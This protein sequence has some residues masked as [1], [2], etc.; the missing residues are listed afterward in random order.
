MAEE[1]EAAEAGGSGGGSGSG[2]GIGGGIGGSALSAAGIEPRTPTRRGEVP[3]VATS[4]SAS[5][6]V[7][8]RHVLFF[9]RFKKTASP[10]VPRRPSKR[11]KRFYWIHRGPPS[12]LQC[13]PSRQPPSSAGPRAPSRPAGRPRPAAVVRLRPAQ[14]S[15]PP[16][17]RRRMQSRRGALRDKSSP[18]FNV[19]V[20]RRRGGRPPPRLQRPRRP[21]PPPPSTAS[22]LA[23]PASLSPA[24]PL[25]TFTERVTWLR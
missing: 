12:Q 4:S 3:T 8:A 6:R 11:L 7:S 13:S 16:R 14:Q 22:S 1:A 18:P 24:S 21:L 23:A 9:F 25:E 2:G 10:V 19:F 5:A 20:T 17:H 15:Q